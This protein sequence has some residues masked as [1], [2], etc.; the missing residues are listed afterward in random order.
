MKSKRKLILNASFDDIEMMLEDDEALTEIVRET[1]FLSAT[2]Q[3]RLIEMY[4]DHT[5]NVA[6]VVALV[7][8][9]LN[10]INKRLVEGSTL[11]LDWLRGI[12]IFYRIIEACIPVHN[13]K[14]ILARCTVWSTPIFHLLILENTKTIN[15]ILKG[16]DLKDWLISVA[17]LNNIDS[18]NYEKPFIRNGKLIRQSMRAI[19][20]FR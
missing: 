2:T 7:E 9:Q 14:E 15:E 4:R 6:D 17:M 16:I 11:C 10:M 8:T 19:C 20:D 5:C 1:S 12:L 18:K 3:H 13:E